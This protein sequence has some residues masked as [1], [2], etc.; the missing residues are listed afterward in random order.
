MTTSISLAHKQRFEEIK[1]DLHAIGF[2]ESSFLKVELL[3]FEALSISRVYG[4]D[5]HQNS[6]LSALKNVQYEQYE[7]TKEHTRKPGQRELHIRRFVVKLKKV[8]SASA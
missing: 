6:L 5:P 3:F 2:R 1:K 4:D 7:K 8:L